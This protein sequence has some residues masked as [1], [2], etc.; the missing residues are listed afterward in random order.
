MTC[1]SLGYYGD[2]WSPLFVF[3]TTHQASGRLQDPVAVG[4]GTKATAKF[5]LLQVKSWAALP[6][7]PS[8]PGGSKP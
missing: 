7:L 8:L 5:E 1:G 6:A 3:E 4:R 2:G